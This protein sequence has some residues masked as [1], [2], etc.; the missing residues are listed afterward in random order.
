MSA[1]ALVRLEHQGELAVVTLDNPPLN[2]FNAALFRALTE[3]VAQLEADAPRGVLFRAEGR[4]VSG[5]VD[6]H[7]FAALE[8]D[9]GRAAAL[10]T[11]LLDIVHRVEELPC[12]TVCAAHG[13]CLTA[14]FELSLACDL[15]LAARSARFGLVEIVVGLTGPRRRGLRRRRPRAGRSPGRRSHARPRSHQADRRR[16][17]D[18]RTAGR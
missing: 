4:V 6:V 13:L 3:T 8:G 10:W 12:P 16:R 17:R 5:G 2:L 18:R 9:T 15:L 14:A 11:E 1:P 7:E